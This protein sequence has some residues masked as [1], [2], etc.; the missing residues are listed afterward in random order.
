MSRRTE[1]PF[2]NKEE[3]VKDYLLQGKDKGMP[4]VTSSKYTKW[5]QTCRFTVAKFSI[6]KELISI[7][8]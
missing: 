6:R 2:F 3:L 1:A 7:Q 5:K 8:D 4:F